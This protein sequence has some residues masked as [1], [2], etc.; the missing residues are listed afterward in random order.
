MRHTKFKYCT[1]V[2][3]LSAWQTLNAMEMELNE[4]ANLLKAKKNNI[5]KKKK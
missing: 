3:K 5:T 4:M 2:I 1:Y